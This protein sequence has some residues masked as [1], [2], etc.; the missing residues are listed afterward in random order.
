MLG[1]I[2][3]KL[4]HIKLQKKVSNSQYFSSNWY[5]ENYK[6][7]LINFSGSPLTH[8]LTIGWK[9][10]N[11]PSPL[12]STKKYL[13]RYKDV[14][15][16]GI[17]PLVHYVT[18]GFNEE[19][20]VDHA[21]NQ[22]IKKS[23][24]NCGSV[25]F[26]I[27]GYDLATQNYRVHNFFQPLM[28]YG[29]NIKVIKDR[30][31]LLEIDN[32]WDIIV[33]NRI[34][35]G[36]QMIE[37]QINYRK[38]GGILI[39]DIDDLIFNPDK[40]KLQD[41]F[42]KRDKQG[43]DARLA[44]MEKIKASVLA[45]DLVTVTTQA[46][47]D[48]VNEFGKR[49][50]V[51]PNSLQTNMPLASDKETD[52][53]NIC[54]L[55]G[56]ATHDKDFEEC[57]QALI[58]V[59]RENENVVLNIVGE[60]ALAEE[61]ENSSQL[62]RHEFMSHINMLIF[63]SSMDINLAPL[64]LNNEFTECKSELKIFEAAFYGVPTVASATAAF[65]ATIE[66][67]VNGFIASNK[68]QWYTALTAL[69][70]SNEYR[71]KIGLHAKET[72]SAI[73]STKVVAAKLNSLYRYLLANKHESLLQISNTTLY[74]FTA[75]NTEI[76]E[77]IVKHC[78]LLDESFYKHNYPDLLKQNGALHY[79]KFGRNELRKPSKNFDGWW[80]DVTNGEYNSQ[81]THYNPIVHAVFHASGK[82]SLLKAPK[83]IKDKHT[84]KLP[85]DYKRVCIFAGYDADGLVDET[86]VAYI[87]EL[88]KYCDVYFMGDCEYQEG[89]IEKLRPHV[90]NAWSERHGQYDFGSYKNLLLG[91]LGWNELAKYDEVLLANDSVYL[92]SSLKPV[93]EKM[94]QSDCAWW[95]MQATKGMAFTKTHDSQ[96]LVRNV[97]HP[98][99]DELLG[100]FEQTPYYDFHVGSYFIAFR[101]NVIQDVGFRKIIESIS[102]VNKK[103]LILDFEVGI[104]RY[105]VG[106]SFKLETFVE[107]LH[108]FHPVYTENLFYLISEKGFPF[109][110]RYLLANNHYY[111]PQLGR[112]LDEY[113]LLVDDS[114]VKHLHRTIGQEQLTRNLNFSLL[115]AYQASA[116]EKLSDDEF[117]K[118]DTKIAK[119]PNLW[120]FPVCYYDHLLTGND[121]ALFEHVKN[122]P[123]IRKVILTRSKSVEM[124]GVN[125]YSFDINLPEAQ[126]IILRAKNIFLKHGPRINIPY[127]CEYNIRNFVNLWHGIPLKRIGVSSLDV[128]GGKVTEIIAHNRPNRCVISSS[129][130][131]RLAMT[132]AFYP[133]TYGQVPITGLPRIDFINM[134]E[135]AL[136]SDFQRELNKLR[137]VLSG[138]KLVLYAPTFRNSQAD[139]YY[140]FSKQELANYQDLLSS[141]NA[142][143][144]VREHMADSAKSYN[145]TLKNIGCLNLS[146]DN[147]PNI[148]VLYR[149]ADVLVTDYSSCYIDFLSTRK[150]I[151]SFAYDLE[152][153]MERE[154]GFYYGIDD[155]FPGAI[156]TDFK[157]MLVCLE[158]AM[159]SGVK[160]LEKYERVRQVFFEFDD[161]LSSQRVA[162]LVYNLG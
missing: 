123:R 159:N 9:L 73:F 84:Y 10:G 41:S 135:S 27:N 96:N 46:L 21:V 26:V 104:S 3:N 142:V 28:A 124:T 131:D 137:D 83:I 79:S 133:L 11:D 125:V 132:A 33:F 43:Q 7:Q 98:M 49:S 14:R 146:S 22:V 111:V 4:R 76:S 60:L 56:T 136:P 15:D 157:N 37:A 161:Q 90:V 91:K 162:E 70:E 5:I 16:S 153:Y 65:T 134:E 92:L 32:K 38:N 57:E 148:E 128:D 36:E 147:Y 18:N 138:R 30:N 114:I 23:V 53:I 108:A 80:Y 8:Y 47:A 59:L 86:L 155:V 100:D 115:D 78:G 87:A 68:E 45:S 61:L 118:L 140:D 31:A 116:F 24:K 63:L 12:F 29:W 109:L 25:L 2:L 150:P 122:D 143:L 112:L 39:H 6:Q 1:Y 139:G 55:S 119:D 81:N 93:F 117:K 34:A 40:A 52:L 149:L 71:E 82:N 19:R 77:D 144:G 110:K 72:I 101:K 75:Q 35:A 99:T 152:N 42:I 97:S 67:S 145:E 88:S 74:D 95:G 13:S 62:V 160:D 105:L 85:S 129:K 113:D 103:K 58:Q 69:V 156:C 107:E 127:P 151:V 89:E 17:C 54:Y 130:I 158:E 102:L 20:I 64:E 66:D 48:Q 50:F 51:I 121:R 141:N 44:A 126:Q 154:R 94:S 106:R 120:V